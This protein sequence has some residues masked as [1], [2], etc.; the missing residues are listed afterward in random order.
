MAFA[1]AHPE[2]G[3]VL[4]GLVAELDVDRAAAIQAETSI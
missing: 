4:R 2:Y 3:P 1:L